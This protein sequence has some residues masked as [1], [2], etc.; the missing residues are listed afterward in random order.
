[1]SWPHSQVFLTL[2]SKLRVKH[3]ATQQSDMAIKRALQ[4]KTG[5]HRNHATRRKTCKWMRKLQVFQHFCPTPIQSSRKPLHGTNNLSPFA[6]TF[7]LC[8]IDAISACLSDKHTGRSH[9]YMERTR[10][11][12][13]PC[14]C[15]KG[16]T[17]LFQ[18]FAY[19][20]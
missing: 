8:A 15:P 19:C 6:S 9:T 10:I 17:V 3:T 7:L 5:E 2:L 14:G 18:A 13:P 16:R 11:G 20:L 12:F 1:M 4:K